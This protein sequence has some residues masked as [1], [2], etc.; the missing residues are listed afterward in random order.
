M[1]PPTS[2]A[3]ITAAEAPTLGVLDLPCSP[4]FDPGWQISDFQYD[5]PAS[6]FFTEMGS[7]FNGGWYVS[8]ALFCQ[9]L[10]VGNPS[11]SRATLSLH[12]ARIMS[13]ALLEQSNT[14]IAPVPTLPGT[15]VS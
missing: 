15:N 12:K 8:V 5:V 9:L 11:Q 1:P 7:F 6:K 4:G 14:S 3:H 2:V 13:L 10:L